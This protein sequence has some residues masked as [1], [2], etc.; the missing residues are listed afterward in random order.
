MRWRMYMI[1]FLRYSA[2]FSSSAFFLAA[3]AASCYTSVPAR[4]KMFVNGG[5]QRNRGEGGVYLGLFIDF[6]FWFWAGFFAFFWGGCAVL[7]CFGLLFL[8]LFD[9][10]W[11]LHPR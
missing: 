6:G 2:F 3:A 7:L 11:F 5:M 10:R 9:D 4:K 8:G 1:S